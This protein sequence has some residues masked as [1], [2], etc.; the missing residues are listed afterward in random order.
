MADPTATATPRPTSAGPDAPGP[1]EMPPR[2]DGASVPGAVPIAAAVVLAIALAVRLRAG[3][4]LRRSADDAA[5][6]DAS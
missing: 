4:S 2:D 5:P 1:V 3:R 6:R